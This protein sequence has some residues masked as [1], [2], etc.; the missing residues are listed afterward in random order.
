MSIATT[1]H[2][3][4]NASAPR[5]MR[6]GSWTALVLTLTLSAPARKDLLDI[7]KGPESAADSK[8]EEEGP[9]ARCIRSMMM[10]RF[11][12]DAVISR[13]TTSS[14]PWSLYLPASST[15][16][17]ASLAEEIRAFHH[18]AVLEVEAGNDPSREHHG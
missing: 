17:P 7:L 12:F 13:K 18:P 4:P 9:A 11:S 3:V 14:A 15:G 2:C 10:P 1:M 8:R 16:S 5:V 6:A